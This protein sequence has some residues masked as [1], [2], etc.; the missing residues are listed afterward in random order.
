MVETAHLPFDELRG[1]RILVVE[2]EYMTA[3]EITDLLAES[4]ADTI[5]PVAFVGDAEILV[6]REDRIDGAIL[7]VNLHGDP[8]WPVIDA[9]LARNIPVV[10]ETGYDPSAIPSAYAHLP[11]CEKPT[12]GQDLTRALARA[13]SA[14]SQM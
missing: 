14:A 12:G 5:G 9:L 8:I 3:E 4:G 11:R 13:L 6:A 7:D 1:R 10:L 2:D